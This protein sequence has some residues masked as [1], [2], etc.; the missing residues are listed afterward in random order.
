MKKLF[1]SADI[2]GTSGI[3]HWDETEKSKAHDYDYFAA[4]MTREVCAACEGAHDA[5]AEEIVVKDAHDTGRNVNGLKNAVSLLVETRGVGLGRLHIQRR[6]HTQVTTITSA[7]T[8][9]LGKAI[10]TLALVGVAI[11][12]FFGIIDFRQAMWVIVAIVFVGSASLIVNS[13][14]SIEGALRSGPPGV[15]SFRIGHVFPSSKEIAANR[16]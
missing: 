9:N 4:Q 12:W 15:M 7:L 3:A 8:G 6:V 1:I 2:E 10:A 16:P 11:T 5:G 14:R 13:L